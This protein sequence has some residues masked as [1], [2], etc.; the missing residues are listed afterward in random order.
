MAMATRYV[1]VKVVLEQSYLIPMYDDG[2][3]SHMD[4]KTP[5]Q[6]VQEWFYDYPINSYHASRDGSQIGNSKRVIATEIMPIKPI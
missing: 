2:V 1:E 6:L 3:H 5:A 4:G